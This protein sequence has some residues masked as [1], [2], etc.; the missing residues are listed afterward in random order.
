MDYGRMDNFDSKNNTSNRRRKSYVLIDI[1][2][3]KTTF[4]GDYFSKN[5]KMQKKS[6][7]MQLKFR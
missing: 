4:T 5:M 3:K 6:G 7:L 2:P 1:L